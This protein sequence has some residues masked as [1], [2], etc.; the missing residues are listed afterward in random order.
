MI[1]SPFD[2]YPRGVQQG[3][4]ACR[5]SSRLLLVLF[6]VMGFGADE[7]GAPIVLVSDQRERVETALRGVGRSG[8][9]DATPLAR[10]VFQPVERDGVA[11]EASVDEDARQRRLVYRVEA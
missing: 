2:G 3:N 7:A 10:H 11:G 5:T 8:A 4:V 9:R 6:V 1:I